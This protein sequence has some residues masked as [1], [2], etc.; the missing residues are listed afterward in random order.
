MYPKGIP[1]Y[2]EEN[3]ENI[4]K[5]NKVDLVLLSYS[6][7]SHN[8]VMNIASR[9]LAS[10]SSFALISPEMTMLNSKK[11]V[12]AVCATRTGA[13]KSPMTEYIS[14]FFKSKNKK[15][16]II[17]HPMPY[18]NL[19]KQEVQ[20][21]SSIKDLEINNC[22]LEE[23]EDYERH[24]LNGIN[25]YS[26]VN[27]SKILKLAEKENDILIWDG[28]NNDTPFFKPNLHV[29]IADASR[30]NHEITYHPGE[31]NFRMCNIIA[32]IS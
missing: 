25:L 18:G 10:G 3:L 4:I 8:Q 23:R 27:Y 5:K 16:G 31:T 12:V 32:F 22:T 28:G 17:R 24:I 30:S 13:G 21:Y 2:K 7:L 11:P 26:G 15:V 19:V 9:A 20:K 14:L 6:D 29:T 1:I